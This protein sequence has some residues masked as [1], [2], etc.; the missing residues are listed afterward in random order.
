VC[1]DNIIGP[2]TN[3]SSRN[4]NVRDQAATIV[5]TK[6]APYR[7]GPMSRVWLGQAFQARRSRLAYACLSDRFGTIPKKEGV[8]T[9]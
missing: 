7:P 4:L 1:E 6:D 5:L 3:G 2:H 9:A 8:L